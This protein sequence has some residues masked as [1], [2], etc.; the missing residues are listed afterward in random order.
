MFGLNSGIEF[1]PTAHPGLWAEE[2]AC[3]VLVFEDERVRASLRFSV[4]L[5]AGAADGLGDGEVR[6]RLRDAL[7]LDLE[8]RLPDALGMSTS[9]R[10]EG[11]AYWV[12]GKP[13]WRRRDALR[14]L[15]YLSLEPHGM[16]RLGAEPLPEGAECWRRTL[17]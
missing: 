1:E 14:R 12:S 3:S 16:C 10:E 11:G 5:E 7:A 6:D 8:A 17:R 4:A 13:V 2:A 15:G 9:E